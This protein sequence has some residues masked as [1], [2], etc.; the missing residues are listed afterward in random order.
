MVSL[1]DEVKNYVLS[2]G[3]NLVG[4]CSI[5]SLKDEHKKMVLDFLPEAKTAVVYV[6]RHSFTA[7][8]SKNINI[9]KYDTLT[10]YENIGRISLNLVRFLEDKGF[11]AAPVP[12]YLPIKM[13]KE[14]LG[15]I[16][17]VS[18]RH[19]AVEAGLGVLGLNRLLITKEYGPK[20]R[21]GAVITSANLNPDKKMEEKFCTDCMLCVETCPVKAIG[22]DGTVN[23][24]KCVANGIR[25]GLPAL[26]RFIPDLVG[27]S[28]EKVSKAVRDPFFWNV[29]QTLTLGAF[30]ECFECIRICPVGEKIK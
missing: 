9:L 6:C 26:T 3:A 10:I 15:L 14:T 16:G 17:D 7:L 1:T 22:K 11:K 24:R 2:Q 4:I 21:I 18:L 25:Y 29:W 30:Y 27:K 20:V 12:P 13:S 23:V 28:K 5:D 19:L 8:N